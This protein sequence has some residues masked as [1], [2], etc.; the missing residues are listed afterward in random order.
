MKTQKLALINDLTSPLFRIMSVYNDNEPLRRQYENNICAFHIG[1]GYLLSVAHPLQAEMTFF[2]SME[3]IQFQSTIL[4]HLNALEVQQFNQWYLF[5]GA[6]NK[7][8]LN[9]SDV[10]LPQLVTILQKINY[11]TRVATLYLNNVCKPYLVVQQRAMQ[12]FNNQVVHAQFDPTLILTDPLSQRQTYLI[13]TELVEAYLSDDIALYRII[14]TPQD[15]VDN[16]PAFEMD[17]EVYDSSDKDF[18]CLQSAPSD[19]NPGRMLNEAN[20]EGLID[21]FSVQPE[22][23]SGNYIFQGLRYL[24]KGYFRFGSSGAPYIKWEEQSSTFKV[25]AVQS[26]ACPIQLTINNNS[27]GNFQFINA[28]AT[29]LAN[30]IDRI[31]IHINS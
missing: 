30:V 13:E 29:P 15:I 25:N 21:Q 12:Y 16:L 3:E 18:F 6:T 11:D 7:R 31:N 22:R 28:I 23:I 26:E 27:N 4:A 9:I 5:D 17:T 2:R 24:I 20:I 14:N 1:K 10:E 19:A 8:Y